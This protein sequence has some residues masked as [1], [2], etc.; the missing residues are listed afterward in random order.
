MANV[1]FTRVISLGDVGSDCEGV[2]RALI[3][4]GSAGVTLSAFNDQTTER[5]RTWN[6]QKRD[7]LK[8]Y[9][10]A[11][12]D[13]F[14]VDGIYGRGV[15][16]EL[17]P[18]F[19]AMAAKLMADWRP[20][21]PPLI[22]P[23]QGFNS[24]HES[25]WQ[26]YSTGRSMHLFD[27]GTWNPRSRLPSGAPSDHAVHPAFAFDLGLDPDIGW[28]HD[29]ARAFFYICLKT[30]AVEYVILGNR[31]GYRRTGTVGLYGSGDHYNHV[32]VSGNR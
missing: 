24:L 5:R 27:L 32:H 16:E 30:P 20:P 29:T 23:V 26:V 12:G 25:L 18:H 4:E 17:K 11:L 15:H 8:K 28:E 19:D 1:R 22:E 6:A 9:E 2:G 21:P 3:R 14:S 31:I 7:W 10:R 13:P